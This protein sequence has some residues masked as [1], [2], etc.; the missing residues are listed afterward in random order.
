MRCPRL[1]D[2]KAYATIRFC[3]EAA[4]SLTRELSAV[5]RSRQRQ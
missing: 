4:A 2:L 1:I 3:T 5:F